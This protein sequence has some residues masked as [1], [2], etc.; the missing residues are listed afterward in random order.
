[1]NDAAK[2]FDLRE[3]AFLQAYVEY[4]QDGPCIKS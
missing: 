1:M 2:K 3:F 4:L